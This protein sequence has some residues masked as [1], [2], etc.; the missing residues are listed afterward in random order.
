MMIKKF[1]FML[2][3]AAVWFGPLIASLGWGTWGM[4]GASFVYMIVFYLAASAATDKDD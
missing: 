3:L 2:V 4:V 1:A